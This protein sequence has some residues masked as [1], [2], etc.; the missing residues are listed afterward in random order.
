MVKDVRREEADR[1]LRKAEEFYDS[2]LENY[3]KG[4]YNASIFDSSQSVILANDAFCVFML[5][6]RPSKDHR[7]AVKLHIEAAAGSENKKTIVKESLEKRTEF[8]Y[9]EREGSQKEANLL[10]IK[11]KRF[12][13]WVRTRIKG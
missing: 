5:G 8:G 6:K 1:F 4:R 11:S 7:E 13:D 12:L 3:Q 2:A 10:L 9:T